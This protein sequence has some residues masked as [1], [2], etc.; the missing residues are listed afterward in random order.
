MTILGIILSVITVCLIIGSILHATYF[1]NK[2]EAI[3]P[4]GQLVDV[5][6]A[7]MHVYKMGNG[8]ETII[9]LPGMG[10]AL[11]SADFGPLMRQLSETYTVVTLEYFGVG[12]S[13]QTQRPR[14][15]ENYVEE[16]RLALENA[17]I[18]GPY[19]LMPHSISSIYSEYYASTY[20]DEVQ[21][22]I[23]LD[24]TSSA[25][26]GPDMP[27]FVKSIL[28]IAKAQQAVGLT[29][30]LAPLVTNKDK[31]LNLG[32]TDKEI[33]DLLYYAGFSMNDNTLSQIANSS[34]FIKDTNKLAY[35]EHVP[36]FKIISKHTYETKNSQLK[37]TPQEYQMQHLERI[38]EKAQYEIL[39]GTHFIYLNQV[40][41]IS[42]I[43]HAFLSQAYVN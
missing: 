16:I 12:F 33:S 9:L 23:S 20:P 17:E 13:T 3:K 40:K 10:V 43:T 31:L 38:G 34:D 37:I 24:G 6:D 30:I 42:D 32:Y 36:Y 29:S 39:E 11:P 19:I 41:Q 4:Y 1:K 26:I 7:H 15:T 21:A 5:Y 18:E 22:I 28:G 35:P 27:G 8:E 2:K 25:Y 14:T